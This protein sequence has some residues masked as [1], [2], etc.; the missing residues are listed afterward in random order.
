MNTN[1]NTQITINPENLTIEEIDEFE[2][3][4]EQ[5]RPVPI[6]TIQ[7][8]NDDGKEIDI[9]GRILSVNDVNEFQRDDGSGNRQRQRTTCDKQLLLHKIPPNAI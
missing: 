2:G 9:V 3:I 7:E 5:L 1:F 6:G 8:I 4:R